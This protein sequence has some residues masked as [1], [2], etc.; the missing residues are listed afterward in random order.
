MSV[1]LVR[2]GVRTPQ[3]E[4]PVCN[5]CLNLQQ[6]CLDYFDD[7]MC[8]MDPCVRE[9][10]TNRELKVKGGYKMSFQELIQCCY[11]FQNPC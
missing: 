2:A 6:P 1:L 9:L 3:E 10:D 7:K 5:A 8:F 4:Q 11:S